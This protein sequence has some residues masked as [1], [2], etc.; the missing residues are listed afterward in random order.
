MANEFYTAPV[1]NIPLT[2]IRAADENADRSSVQLAFDKLP[3]E[4][5]MK[6]DVYGTDTGSDGAL[7]EIAAPYVTDNYVQGTMITFEAIAA[8]LG[9][10]NIQVNEFAI[11]ELVDLFGN[12]LEANIITAGQILTVVYS[13]AGKWRLVNSTT[14]SALATATALQAATDAQTAQAAAEAAQAAAEAT[15]VLID[16]Y[17]AIVPQTGGGELTA[18]RINEIRDGSAYTVPLANS[19]PLDAWIVIELP[20]AY[21]ASVPTVNATGGDNFIVGEGT[22]TSIIFNSGATWMRLTSDGSA[23]WRL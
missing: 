11:S 13:S 1:D 18:Q 7:Y 20:D 5:D 2:T 22:D 10:A 3:T 8:N 9:P 16:A 12:P 23:N 17:S 6:R 14:D 4:A 15:L 19:V 21:E